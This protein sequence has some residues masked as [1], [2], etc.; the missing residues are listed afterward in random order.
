MNDSASGD[1]MYQAPSSSDYFSQIIDE[2]SSCRGKNLPNAMTVDVEDYFQVSAFD[3]LISRDDWSG[4]PSRLPRNIE[5]VL[6]LFESENV[7]ATFFTLGWVCK[8]MPGLVREIAA[9]GHEIASHGHDH[10]RVWS[11]DR[12]RFRDDAEGSRKR[13]EDTSGTLVTGYRAPSF[14]IGPKTPWAHDVLAEAGYIYSSSIYPVRHDHYGLPSAPR[15]PF[16]FAA[17]GLLEIPLSSV[18]TLGRNWPCAGGGYFRLLPIAYS[19]WAVRRINQRDK[20]PTVF[21]FHPWEIDSGQP[22][23]PG[24]SAKTRFRHY[25]NL[26]VFEKRLVKILRSFRWDRMDRIFL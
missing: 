16:R 26:D 24:V 1:A 18:R 17:D 5:R 21:Y 13:L 8:K 7:K 19:S 14:S 23:I 3:N 22:R 10:A 20:M 2:S 25:T 9:A 6:D 11:F 12:K 4:M 15:F